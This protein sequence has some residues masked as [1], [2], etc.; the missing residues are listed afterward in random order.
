MLTL[1]SVYKWNNEHHTAVTFSVLC[2]MRVFQ[3]GSCLCSPLRWE[4]C[5][6]AFP[7]ALFAPYSFV[8][9]QTIQPVFQGGSDPHSD[10]AGHIAKPPGKAA[11]LSQ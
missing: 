4:R 2:R 9:Y 3:A 11:Y 5:W 7:A 6:I 8:L 1:V 10:T